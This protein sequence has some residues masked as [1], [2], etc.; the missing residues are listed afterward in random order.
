MTIINPCNLEN[1]LGKFA[2]RADSEVVVGCE[3]FYRLTAKPKGQTANATFGAIRNRLKSDEAFFLATIAELADLVEGGGTFQP[4]VDMRGALL[5]D[6]FLIGQ[7]AFP[8]DFDNKERVLLPEDAL[9]RCRE[10]GIY[11]ALLYFTLSSTQETPKYRLV[12][13]NEIPLVGANRNRLVAALL[14]IFPEADRACA[15]TARFYLGSNGTVW[16][17]YE[18]GCFDG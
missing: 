11:P 13:V 3:V 16:R 12:F 17:L 6:L 10:N 7:Q 15:D 1:R 18:R 2:I 9:E 5:N 14:A 8:L 4:Y